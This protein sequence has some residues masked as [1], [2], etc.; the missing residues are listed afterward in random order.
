MVLELTSSDFQSGKPIPR[1]CTG[2]GEDRSPQLGWSKIPEGT[3]EL[4]L[5]CDDPDAP[6]R[7]R[8]FTGSSMAWSRT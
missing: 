3:E 2:E 6:S 7:T 5:I 4:A 1:V 8:G